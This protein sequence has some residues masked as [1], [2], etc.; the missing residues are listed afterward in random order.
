MSSGLLKSRAT[1]DRL[2][3]EFLKSPTFESKDRYKTYRQNY[4]KTV[5]AAKKLYFKTKLQE[6]VKNPKKTWETLNEILENNKK[7]DSVDKINIDG[8]PET[9]PKKIASQ[10][11]TFFTNAGK[12][13]SES[14][15]PVTKQP[16]DYI[17]Y[18]R[19]IPL[20]NL[21]QLLNM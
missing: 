9:D 12:N 20:L 1:K 13:I 7:S 5:R 19:E 3:H 16:E 21:I 8:R 11:N 6:N 2:Y 14:V 15:P 4:F 18:G 10:F 17:D